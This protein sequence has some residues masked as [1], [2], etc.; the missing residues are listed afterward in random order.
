[1]KTKKSL[2]I[3]FIIFAVISIALIFV[4]RESIFSKLPIIKDFYSNTSI[5]IIS[6][7]SPSEIYINGESYGE[8]NQ[9][10]R[11]LSA[12]NYKIEL[13]R[14]S[15]QENTFYE[16]F[17]T[18]LQL[19]KNSESFIN[20]EIGPK[21]LFHGYVIYYTKNDSLSSDE[22]TITLFSNVQNPYIMI[23]GENYDVNSDNI[24]E[25][26][27]GSYSIIVGKEGHE[28]IKIPATRVIEG[29]NLNLYVFLFPIPSNY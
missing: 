27:N 14:I 15:E 29:N 19:E 23:N 5:E 7:N 3:L 6:Q 10:I 25:L 1:M 16:S 21:G 8:T 26:K 24:F 9:T 11:N 20:I 12:G 22:G 18:N 17:E 13:K 4:D 28:E 2:I